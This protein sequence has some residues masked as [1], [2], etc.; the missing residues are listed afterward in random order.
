MG[1]GGPAVHS[2]SREIGLCDFLQ[3]WINSA[4]EVVMDW[5]NL[6]ERERECV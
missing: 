5:V 1:A 3:L 4:G 6:A 2:D